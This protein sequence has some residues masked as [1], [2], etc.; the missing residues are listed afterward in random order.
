MTDAKIAF[1]LALP[2]SWTE[3]DLRPQTRDR[4]IA[5]LVQEMIDDVPDLRQRRSDIVAYLRETAR[6]AWDV[7]CKFCGTFI[8]AAED[9]IVPGNITIA[10]LPKAPGGGDDGLANVLDQLTTT[11]MVTVDEYWW[12][13]TVTDLPHLGKAARAFGVQPVQPVRT[14]PA[15]PSVLMQ[16]YVPFDG[17]VILIAAGSPATLVADELLELFDAVTSTFRLE[18][19]DGEE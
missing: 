4:S 15:I 9:G 5:T 16:T 10:V 3:L 2:P 7:G 17:G 13:T 11:D 1:S 12:Q 6:Q 14:R 8:E 18:V 19:L